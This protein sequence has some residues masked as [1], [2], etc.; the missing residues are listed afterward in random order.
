M[1]YK[2]YS[3]DSPAFDRISTSA[4]NV[5][6][7]FIGHGSLM[8]TM[9]NMNIYIDPVSSSG[10][11]EG[12]PKADLILI[13]VDRFMMA[14][15]WDVLLK[16]KDVHIPLSDVVKSFSSPADCKDLIPGIVGDGAAAEFLSFTKRAS[17]QKTMTG[18][19]PA[20]RSLST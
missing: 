11:Y 17:P 8:F 15:K 1:A 7:Y 20:L 9:N 12:L 2:A 14:I 10:S 19:L 5:D 13:T 6:M 18:A 16:A 3:Q 4:G